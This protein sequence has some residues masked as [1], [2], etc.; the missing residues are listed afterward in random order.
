MFLWFYVRIQS[1]LNGAIQ[2]KAEQKS[3]T[4]CLYGRKT[5]TFYCCYNTKFNYNWFISK[6]HQFDSKS[7]T[8]CPE[9]AEHSKFFWVVLITPIVKEREIV[10]LLIHCFHLTHTFIQIPCLQRLQ[11]L[12]NIAYLSILSL[13]SSFPRLCILIL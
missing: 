9:I 2:Q 8:C 1:Y 4:V 10:C 13:V 5:T 11:P 12:H 3:T 7:P 6:L